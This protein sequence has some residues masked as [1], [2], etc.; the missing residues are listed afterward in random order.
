MASHEF[1]SIRSPRIKGV[2]RLAKRTFRQRERRFLAEGPQAVREALT[3]SDGGDGRPHGA[4]PGVVEVYATAEAMQRHIDLVD[5]AR[6]AGV[7]THRVSLDVMSELAQ[8]VT[9]QGVIAVCEFVDVPLDD[10]GDVRLVVVLSHVRDPGNAGTVLRTADAA[11]ADA[12][13]FT[14]A[15]V[16]P[17]NGKCVRASA[18]SLFHLPV[19]VGVPVARAVDFLRGAGA[20]VWAA[21]GGGPRDLHGVADDGD[22]DGPVGWVFGNEAWGL[23]EDVVTLTDGAVSVPIYGGAESLNLATAAAVCLYTTAR[24][25]RRS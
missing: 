18:G 13:I 5:A 12:V 17:Y 9:P 7:P 23:P 19:V 3:A 1:T 25:Q 11:G 6:A 2:R 20:R 21:D 14:D 10:L 4:A 16:D 22:L 8:T 24:Q 15:S